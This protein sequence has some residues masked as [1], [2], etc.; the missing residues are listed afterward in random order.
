MSIAFGVFCT[1]VG[2][3]TLFPWLG[4][5]PG[6][7]PLLLVGR[8]GGWLPHPWARNAHNAWYSLAL[9]LLSPVLLPAAALGASSHGP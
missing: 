3:A 2:A 1:V 6:L 9:L 7:A 4:L 5:P 8:L